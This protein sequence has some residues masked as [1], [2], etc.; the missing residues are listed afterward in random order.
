M[1]HEGERLRRKRIK[2]TGSY[3]VFAEN[4]HANDKNLRK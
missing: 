3:F 2:I 1:R 4:I